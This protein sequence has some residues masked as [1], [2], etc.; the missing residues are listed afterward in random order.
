MSSCAI[1]IYRLWIRPKTQKLLAQLNPCNYCGNL[2]GQNAG[3]KTGQVVSR[4]WYSKFRGEGEGMEGKSE[5][6][7][8]IEVKAGAY[9]MLEI[10]I[11]Y[12]R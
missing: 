12:I 3:H 8:N 1:K 11:E 7:Q 6:I 10:I 9:F 2:Q 4:L 5:L